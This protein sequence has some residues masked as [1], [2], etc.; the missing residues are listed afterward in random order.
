LMKN[1]KWPCDVD[2]VKVRSAQMKRLAIGD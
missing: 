1:P 2:P